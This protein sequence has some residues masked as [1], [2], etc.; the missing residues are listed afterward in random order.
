MKKLLTMMLLSA[1]PMFMSATENK[2]P[3]KIT[4]DKGWEFSQVG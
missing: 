4:L 1:L 3:E 2:E